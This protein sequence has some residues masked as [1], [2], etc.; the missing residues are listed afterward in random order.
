P[1][2]PRN[3]VVV[4]QGFLDSATFG[5]RYALCKR[6]RALQGR[7]KRSSKPRTW[8]GRGS[9]TAVRR[10]SAFPKTIDIKRA[11]QLVSPHETT[12]FFLAL[13]QVR[14]NPVASGKL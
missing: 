9:T 6:Q 8:H 11:L 12:H 4:S 14:V 10:W 7:K 1:G 2:S 3:L 5:V 13:V